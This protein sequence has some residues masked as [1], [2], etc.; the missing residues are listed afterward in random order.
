MERRLI[1]VNVQ[2]KSALVAGATSGPGLAT[3]DAISGQGL[4]VA[5]FVDRSGSGQSPTEGL[6]G[7]AE[8]V[9]RLSATIDSLL[10]QVE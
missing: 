10:G 8:Q 6:R 9:R 1:L 7:M 2:K 4:N 5:R 3:A